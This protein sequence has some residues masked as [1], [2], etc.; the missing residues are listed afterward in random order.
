M[1]QQTYIDDTNDD[2]VHAE[3]DKRP[4]LSPTVATRKSGTPVQILLNDEPID[5]DGIENGVTNRLLAS[6]IY[7]QNAYRNNRR[8]HHG[9]ERWGR[10]RLGIASIGFVC[11]IYFCFVFGTWVDQRQSQM[12]VQI[13]PLDDS[14][15]GPKGISHITHY[16]VLFFSVVVSFVLHGKKKRNVCWHF[17]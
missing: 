14:L 4:L 8:Y 6:A 16:C 9:S 2:L 10:I 1:I 12:I 17:E 13:P 7:Q 5:D 3:C 15:P 11:V